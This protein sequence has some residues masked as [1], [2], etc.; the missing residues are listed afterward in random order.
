VIVAA[1]SYAQKQKTCNRT[2]RAN[3]VRS[4]QHQINR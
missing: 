3:Q 2:H 1:A 4:E